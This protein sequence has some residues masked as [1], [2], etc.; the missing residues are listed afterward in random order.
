[1]NEFLIRKNNT[2]LYWSNENGWGFKRSATRF[3]A[4]EKQYFFHLP[5]S[6]IWEEA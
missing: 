6:S 2:N 1:M 5:L 3:T 4:E